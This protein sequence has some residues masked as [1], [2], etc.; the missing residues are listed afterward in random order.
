MRV[1]LIGGTG[2]IG[3][4]VA[5]QA[6]DAGHEVRVL[7][8]S[9]ESDRKLNGAP[10]DI[11]RGST[12][13]NDKVA[14]EARLVDAVVYLALSGVTGAA[15][16]DVLLID[17]VLNALEGTNKSFIL[18]SGLAV[19]AGASAGVVT[20]ETPTDRAIPA[21]AWRADL[22]QKVLDARSRGIIAT[23]IRPSIVYGNGGGSPLIK[24]YLEHVAGGGVPFYLGAGGNAIATVHVHDLARVYLHILQTGT[25]SGS[26][27]V[28][29]GAV[30]GFDL[31]HAA[32]DLTGAVERVVP[33]EVGQAVAALGPS[34]ALLGVDLRVSEWNLVRDLLPAP[35]Q[36]TLLQALAAGDI[37]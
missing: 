4:E 7:S 36:P 15:P 10:V 37:S 32:K 35:L 17:T 30:L 1:L 23:V 2:Y 14:A 27:N 31:A 13:D 20:P 22:E 6:L 18:T 8:R 28:A 34:G 5:R 21:Q 11:V 29:T 33:Y 12:D 26:V 25:A 19:Y 24:S 3:S 9:A 16:A